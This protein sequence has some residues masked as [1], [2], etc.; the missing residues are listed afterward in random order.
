MRWSPN[1]RDVGRRVLLG[2]TGAMLAGCGLGERGAPVPQSDVRL[3][4]AL[5]LPNERFCVADPEDLPRIVAEFN[6][7]GRRQ[8][9]AFGLGPRD[10]LPSSSIIAFSG[11]GENGAFGAG[12]SCGW[13]ETGTRPVFNVVTGISTGALTAPLVF[14]GPSRDGDLREAYTGL[15]GAVDVLRDRGLLA[16]LVDDAVSDTTPLANTI[17]RFMTEELL[18]EIA[19]G[20]RAGRQL[21]IATTNLDA[22]RPVGWNLGAIAASG[23]P[24]ALSLARQVL[25]ASAAVPGLFPPVMIDVTVNGRPHQ[26]MHVD[27]GTY[28]QAYLYPPG[29]G[30]SREARIRQGLT[31][32]EVTAYVVRNGRLTVQGGP[33]RRRALDIA[34]RAISTLISAASLGDLYRIQT[35]TH[36]HGIG[37][38]L[39]YIEDDF[40]AEES[41][42]FDP[43][44]LG[45]LFEYGFAKARRGYP[46]KSGLPV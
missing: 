22:Q 39:A 11:G 35:A 40:T 46:W 44:F 13:T 20:Y 27:G 26:E 17:A 29:L 5:G 41:E 36:R 4:T 33:V 31:P 16:A 8:R 18:A 25:L 3:A 21:I 7:A 28:A 2:G 45:S 38:R 19:E 34:G 12:L 30:E 37:F 9:R 10:P 23:D 14:V 6:E 43:V 42:P 1:P 24:R 32:A 15:R